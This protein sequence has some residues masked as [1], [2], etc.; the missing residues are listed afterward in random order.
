MVTA[1][2]IKVFVSNIL[3]SF[4]CLSVFVTCDRKSHYPKR[5]LLI[6]SLGFGPPLV[7]L[8]LLYAFIIFPGRYSVTYIGVVVFVFCLLA[9]WGRKAFPVMLRDTARYLRKWAIALKNRRYCCEWMVIFGIIAVSLCAYLYVLVT[10]I[11]PEPL[12]GHDITKY[13]IL[14]EYT[15]DAKSL[16]PFYERGIQSTGILLKGSHKPLFVLLATWE[17]MLNDAFGMAGDMYFK[18]VGAYYGVLLWLLLFYLVAK[19]DKWMA[20]I[21]SAALVSGFSFG[22]SLL[23]PHIDMF[24][25]YMLALAIFFFAMSLKNEKDYFSLTLFG[26]YGGFAACS[27]TIGLAFVVIAVVIL[28]FFL[29][30]G[31]PDK[32]R[33][34]FHGVLVM[35]MSGNVFHIFNVI[36]GRDQMVLKIIKAIQRTL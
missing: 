23:S 16:S 25:I 6:Y 29:R 12:Y 8:I 34:F 21:A 32:I 22:E 13:A 26:I 28:P 7:S 11:L 19:R 30:A 33:A 20:V 24:R 36:Y 31:W 10:V 27:H 14:G 1:L 4:I 5:E 9:L 35:M 3:F 17:R 15:F 18:S 2:V